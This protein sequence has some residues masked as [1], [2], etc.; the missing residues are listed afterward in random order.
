MNTVSAPVAPRTSAA[1][2]QRSRPPHLPA[3][4]G[5]G[6]SA[7]AGEPL[8]VVRQLRVLH[9]V[10]SKLPFIKPRWLRA[11]EGVNFNLS[12]GETV[13]LVGESGSGKSTLAKALL[14]VQAV[15]GGSISFGGR[16]LVGLAERDWQHLRR[17][18][19]MVFQNPQDSINPKL[20]VRDVIAEPLQAFEPRLPAAQR[21]ER[22]AQMLRRVGLEAELLEQKA[23]DLSGGQAQRVAIA[24]ALI[25]QPRLLICD[26]AI[27]ALDL[28]AQIEI[29]DL[30]QQIQRDTNLAMLFISHDLAAVRRISHRVMVMYFGRVMEKA[31][32]AVLFD[33]PRHPYTKALLA[34]V[35]G[36]SAEQ[37][38]LLLR[39]GPAPDVTVPQ[40]GCLFVERCPMADERCNRSVPHTHTLR[41]G[42]AVTCHYVS[43]DWQPPRG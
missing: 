16:E 43:E 15:A 8:L 9:R 23:G 35:P 19:Q 41:D 31:D 39:E 34:S 11:V 36:A 12:P 20:R 1:Q 27:S 22:V 6:L 10:G 24:R 33:T 17:D 40:T 3:E 26:E 21:A 29:L 32:A 14:G 13:A 2:P 38:A 7:R 42:S 37:R 18:I 28:S 4:A 25:V 5:A 30:L